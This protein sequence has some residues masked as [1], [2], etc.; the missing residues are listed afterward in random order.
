MVI[1]LMQND[2]FKC[3]A[4]EAELMFEFLRLEAPIDDE[5]ITQCTT[6]RLCALSLMNCT[7]DNSVSASAVMLGMV[8]EAEMMCSWM[9]KNNKPG[10]SGLQD[11]RGEQG[12]W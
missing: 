9:R 5:L 7:R 12:D 2:G 8:K 1:V 4:K 6:I 3:I 10:V 11:R